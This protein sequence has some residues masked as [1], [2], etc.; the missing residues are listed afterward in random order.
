[1]RRGYCH[2]KEQASVLR[3][4]GLSDKE[5]YREGAGAETL[6]ACLRSFRGQP[7]T[8]LLVCPLEETTTICGISVTGIPNIFWEEALDLIDALQNAKNF[9]RFVAALQ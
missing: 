1:M 6:A 7:G 9:R 3:A 5:I 2:T 4:F 8:L